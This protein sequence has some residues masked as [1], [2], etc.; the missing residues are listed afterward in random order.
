MQA[1]PFESDGWIARG[2]IPSATRVSRLWRLL[3]ACS[4]ALLLIGY[5][6]LSVVFGDSDDNLRVDQTASLVFALFFVGVAY[7]GSI[8]IACIHRTRQLFLLRSLFVPHLVVNLVAL[9]NVLLNI[10]SRN[11]YPLNAIRVVGIGL[12]S[13]FSLIYGLASFLIYRE[14]GSSQSRAE[15]GT[16]S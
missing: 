9:F 14:Y 4:A 10:L 13:A 16:P 11:L 5:L 6:I 3:T 15:D 8:V 7:V 2:P 1:P 12:P